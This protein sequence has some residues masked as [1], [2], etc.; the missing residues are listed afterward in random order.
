MLVQNKYH[1]GKKNFK[2]PIGYV[3]HSNHGTN[4]QYKVFYFLNYPN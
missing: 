4:L 2:Q 3:E 1:L